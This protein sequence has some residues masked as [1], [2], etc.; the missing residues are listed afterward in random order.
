VGEY[1]I[2]YLLSV[3][4][5]AAGITIDL[6]TAAVATILAAM[7]AAYPSSRLIAANRRKVLAEAGV[8]ADARV[9]AFAEVVQRDNT[10]LRER[11]SHLEGKLEATERRC[12]ILERLLMEHGIPTP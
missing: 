6:N 1:A 12:D 7:I 3:L 9:N 2:A 4:T 10:T 5:F 11:I 8:A